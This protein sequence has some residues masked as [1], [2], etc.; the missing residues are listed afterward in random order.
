MKKLIDIF[1]ALVAISILLSLHSVTMLC[2]IYDGSS[3]E[4]FRDDISTY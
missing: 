3:A 2:C 1:C 4:E